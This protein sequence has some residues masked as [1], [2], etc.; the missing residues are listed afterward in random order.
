MATTKLVI[1][2]FDGVLAN[3]EIIALYELGKCLTSFGITLGTAELAS[4]FLGVSL[5]DIVTYVRERIGPVD[6]DVF[7][8][9][10]YGALFSRYQDELTLMPGAN[11]L[12]DRLDTLCI[13]Y[14]VASG[15]SVTRLGFAMDILGL[16]PR[17][18]GK[19]FSADLVGVG[20]P[21]PDLFLF[22]ARKMGVDVKD[23][24]VVEDAAAGVDAA[25]AARI[26]C[27]GF[28]GG[29]HLAA[30]RDHYARLLLER[31]ADAIAHDLR[32]VIG[33]L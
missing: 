19:A 1:F 25:R 26:R 32:E 5:G 12:L 17:F 27:L 16:G 6:E 10:W 21:S 2:D 28:V 9:Q 14:C 18:D 23:C 15:G 20:K 22:A 29:D 11:D 31:G 8:A 3:S 13:R 24:L 7:R 33:H 30:D 4:R